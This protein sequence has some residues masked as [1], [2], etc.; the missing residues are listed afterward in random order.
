[1]PTSRVTAEAGFGAPLATPGTMPETATMPAAASPPTAMRQRRVRDPFMSTPSPVV[2]PCP[3]QR[4]TARAGIKGAT[5]RTHGGRQRPW[6]G[7]HAP[8]QGFVS[9]RRL[10]V[11]LEDVEAEVPVAGQDV[12][13]L[14]DVV[15]LDAPEVVASLVDEG[16]DLLQAAVA[17]LEDAEPAGVIADVG[18]HLAGVG[19]D[20][21]LVYREVA[22]TGRER[23]ILGLGNREG[24]DLPDRAGLAHVT[25]DL[26]LE[27]PDVAPAVEHRLDR[28][29]RDRRTNGW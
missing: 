13:L 22:E 20:R 21:H 6:P 23:R 16:A 17:V 3:S 10:Q 2:R 18:E 4:P 27:E 25:G 14:A 9:A 19:V 15:D 26:R 29:G 28:G 5:L 24:V 11:G 7:A 1:M 12:L 8:G